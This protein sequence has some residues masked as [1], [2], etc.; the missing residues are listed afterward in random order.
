V[1]EFGDRHV[2]R[3]LLPVRDDFKKKA[4]GHGRLAGLG[5]CPDDED[6][7]DVDGSGEGDAYGDGVDWGGPAMESVE[8][9]SG[10]REDNLLTWAVMLR[11]LEEGAL[12]QVLAV[13]MV[14]CRP[15]PAVLVAGGCELP[16]HPAEVDALHEMQDAMQH[17]TNKLIVKQPKEGEG[18]EGGEGGAGEGGQ[19]GEGGEEEDDDLVGMP[20][21]HSASVHFPDAHP[22]RRRRYRFATLLL[23]EFLAAGAIASELRRIRNPAVFQ[24]LLLKRLPSGARTICEG[25]WQT[26]LHFCFESMMPPPPKPP[27][28]PPPLPGTP[29]AKALALE[30][31]GI[32]KPKKKKKGE[33]DAPGDAQKAMVAAQA[34]KNKKKGVSARP[35]RS[36]WGIFADSLLVTGCNESGHFKLHSGLRAAGARALAEMLTYSTDASAKDID[37]ARCAHEVAQPDVAAIAK[38]LRQNESNPIRGIKTGVVK[39][40]VPTLKGQMPPGAMVMD[41]YMYA[42]LSKIDL[43]GV[44]AGGD[45]LEA[46][47]TVSDAVIVGEIVG[48]NPTCLSLLMGNNHLGHEAAPYLF[49]GLSMNNALTHLDVSGNNLGPEGAEAVEEFLGKAKVLKSINLARNHLQEAG[50]TSIA[51]GMRSNRSI[52]S[53]D[54]SSNDMLRIG[55]MEIGELLVFHAAAIETERATMQQE[56]RALEAE[57]EARAAAERDAQAAARALEGRPMTASEQGVLAMQAMQDRAA[58]AAMS[59]NFYLGIQSLNIS[60]NSPVEADFTSVREMECEPLRHDVAYNRSWFRFKGASR[61]DPHFGAVDALCRGLKA[62]ACAVTSFDFSCNPLVHYGQDGVIFLADALETNHSLTSINLSTLGSNA[63]HDTNM[64][65]V[66]RAMALNKTLMTVNLSCN[67]LEPDCIPLLSAYLGEHNTLTSL[68]LKNNWLGRV[69][70]KTGLD[71]LKAKEAR[72]KAKQ[73]AEAEDNSRGMLATTLG[74]MGRPQEGGAAAAAAE[75]QEE[76]AGQAHEEG[77]A[78]EDCSI[79]ALVKA[80]KPND[81]LRVLDLRDNFFEGGE[82]ECRRCSRAAAAR[83]VRWEHCYGCNARSAKP[84]RKPRAAAAAAASVALVAAVALRAETYA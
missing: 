51:Q 23:Q 22:R 42:K 73:E 4:A 29:E 34:V 71:G 48:Y 82:C 37:L 76:G 40:P 43:T 16:P 45:R 8:S 84:P 21:M 28:P 56:Q 10:E 27:P 59:D 24:R 17:A 83:T 81:T 60:R 35:V 2:R 49:K 62:D 25:W 31:L 19:G 57:N 50:A 9:S 3:W 68:D 20:E 13:S 77:P 30:M 15:D 54:L 69:V 6:N 7:D 12:S 41:E 33:K 53:L 65:P 18:G 1:R 61:F 80:V 47:L 32:G 67:Q 5:P 63:R 78:D 64:H 66:I 36:A 26:V 52:T 72:E 38:A 79:Y 14:D 55:C 39:L 46:R 74:G 58:A 75:E 11:A 44:D 70:Q